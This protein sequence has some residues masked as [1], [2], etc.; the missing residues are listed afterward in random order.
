MSK[1][2]AIV[3]FAILMAAPAAAQEFK[4]GEICRGDTPAGTTTSNRP[5]LTL[6][7]RFRALAQAQEKPASK[8]I[9]FG[10]W[11]YCHAE[12]MKL[13]LVQKLLDITGTKCCGGAGSG[14]CRV[15]IINVQARTTMVDGVLCNIPKNVTVHEMPE[16]RKVAGC[17]DAAVAMICASQSD[18]PGT[19]CGTIHCAAYEGGT[20]M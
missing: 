16:L 15:S 13:G 1:R 10:W 2:I 8:Q 18:P 14:E 4:T 11:A 6:L 19:E 7:S 3:L 12:L 20:K 17:S 9:K 5:P